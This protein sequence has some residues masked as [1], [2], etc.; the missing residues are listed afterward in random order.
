MADRGNGRI[1]VSAQRRK[2]HC[3]V[4]VA[5]NG[6]GIPEA[7]R[8]RLFEPFVSQGKPG[9]TG[10]GLALVRSVVEAHRGTITCKTSSRGATFTVKLPSD[11]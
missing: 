11:S 7:I 6:S 1:A 4:Y 2:N 10:L 5:D 3:L 9:G 8:D